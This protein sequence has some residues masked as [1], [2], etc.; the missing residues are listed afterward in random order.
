MKH[1]EHMDDHLKSLSDVS[2]YR[3]ES[4]DPDPRGYAIETADGRAIGRVDDLVI[5]TQAMKVRYLVVDPSGVPGDTSSGG[6]H[7][8]VPV[9]DVEVREDTRRVVANRF[10]GSEQTWPREGAASVAGREH[11]GDSDRTRMTRTEEE[12]E[13]GKREV[14]RGEVSVGKHV[15]TEHVSQPVTRRREEVV[16]ERRPVEKGT[17]ADA[18]FRDD[19]IRVPITEEEIVV[20]KR[21][22]VR[23]ELVVGKR[24]V[25]EKDTVEADLRRE[26]FDIDERVRDDRNPTGRHKE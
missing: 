12:L 5:D 17:R 15:E 25:E 10:T 2:D 19:E 4:G 14:N 26:K 7:V 13:I 24:V 3:V 1:S 18:K 9:A 8:L 22:V 11:A 6:R 20:D 23:E 16:V 21:P